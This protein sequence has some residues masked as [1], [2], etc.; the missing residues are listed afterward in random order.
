MTSFRDTVPA[1]PAL[2]G[3]FDRDSATYA[4]YWQKLD[5]LQRGFGGAVSGDQDAVLELRQIAA[6]A[7]AGFL[8]LHVP[9]L[10]PQLTDGY[11]KFLRLDELIA[12]AAQQVPGLV[13]DAEA[14]AA[15]TKLKTGDKPG[16][17]IQQG[18]LLS[19]ILADRRAGSHLCH[20]MLLPRPESA[21]ALAKFI[22][23]G[24]LDFGRVRVTR[25]GAASIITIS[26]PERLNSEDHT[27][28]DAFE[29][30]IDVVLM[31]EQS[32]IGVLRGDVVQHPKYAGR[33]LFG[34]GINLT[35]LYHGQI[36]YL[37]YMTRDMGLV[38]K[39]FRGIARP[40]GDP[41]EVG[42][43]TTEKLWIA[44]VE[45][46]AIG[47]A[48][49]LLLVC[50][51][52]IAEK[53]A[54]MTLPARKEGII[55][56]L[57]NMRLPRFVGDRIARQAILGERRLDCDSPEGRLICDQVVAPEAIEQT[58]DHTII[59]LTGSGVVSAE[60]N[61]RMIRA[62]VEP[63]DLFRQYM[64]AY[65]REQAFCHVSPALV[66]NLEKYWNAQNRKVS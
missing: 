40:D 26:N 2:T 23:D 12:K 35:A 49:Q 9:Y 58:L 48:C 56:G 10:Y 43:G 22:R 13:P 52:V 27:V 61:R 59:H 38:N 17:E 8:D 65:T 57:A 39:L 64:A 7:R 21:E 51:H 16:L 53:D 55:P 15:E 28:I 45:G 3:D 54:Y 41:S 1:A 66:G 18:I 32:K 31:D 46:F 24:A 14:Y 42:G 37:F 50:D 34:S 44:L 62:A 4:P 25:Q 6:S 60:G 29:I 19:K 20:A 5:E 63:F 47:G 11:R 36:P 33:H 30:A